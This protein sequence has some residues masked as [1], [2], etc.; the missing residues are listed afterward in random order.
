MAKENQLGHS[1]SIFRKKKG[2]MQNPN[3]MTLKI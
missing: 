3:L 2:L 1:A